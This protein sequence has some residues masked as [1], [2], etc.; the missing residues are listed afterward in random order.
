MGLASPGV[1]WH[2]PRVLH[3]SSSPQACPTLSHALPSTL[4]VAG[5]LAQTQPSSSV[6]QAHTI[7]PRITLQV[8]RSL[9]VFNGH[10]PGLLLG[11]MLHGSA[12]CHVSSARL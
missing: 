6:A 9:K 7:L 2:F 5:P 1:H 3:P 8:L 10:N 11:K 4:G 12:V